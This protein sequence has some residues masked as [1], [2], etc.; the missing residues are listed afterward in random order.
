[1]LPRDFVLPSVFGQQVD[2][3]LPMAVDRSDRTNLLEGVFTPLARLA[4]GVSLKQ[5]QTELDELAANAN[6]RLDEKARTHVRLANLQAGL[7]GPRRQ[8][9][10]LLLGTAGF[11]LLI[12]CANLANLLL[13]RG[14]ERERELAVR[15]ALGAGG[16]RLAAQVLTEALLLAVGGG[17]AA[18]LLA[19]WTFAGIVSQLPSGVAVLVPPQL[20]LRAL[21]FTF[22]LA[23][24]AG[25]LFALGLALRVQR[26]DVRTVIQSG[27]R[28]ARRQRTYGRAALIAAELALGVVLLAGAG[29]MINSLARMK[30][31]ELG[32]QK[33]DSR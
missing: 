29:L 4:P 10:F 26:T 9:A 18:Y 23:T 31:V 5:A 20:D 3:L 16:L 21:G 17:L 2:F 32:F 12:A 19:Y 28:S 27:T 15:V 8:T 22:A 33:K 6:S 24:A 25:V 30:A 11:V 13:A 7:F 14:S 1:M